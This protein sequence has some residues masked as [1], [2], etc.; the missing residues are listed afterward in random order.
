[1]TDTA[2]RAHRI[3][4]LHAYADHLALHPEIPAPTDLVAYHHTTI[5]AVKDFAAAQGKD[6]I[7]TEENT[8][9]WVNLDLSTGRLRIRHTV[10]GSR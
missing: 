4:A 7:T 6:T 10:I 2:Q 3:A 9:T 8:T 5:A 1:M